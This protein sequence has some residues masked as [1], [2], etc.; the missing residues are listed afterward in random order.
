MAKNKFEIELSKIQNQGVVFVERGESCVYLLRINLKGK[1]AVSQYK[2]WG[3]AVHGRH[4]IRE[5]E[6]NTADDALLKFAEIK[7]LPNVRWS[8]NEK[9]LYAD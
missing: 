4:P 6:Y 2:Y 8:N 7:S 9:L 3:G 1:F 5:W